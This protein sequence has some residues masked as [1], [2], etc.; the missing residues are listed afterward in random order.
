MTMPKK[1]P[2]LIAEFF[3]WLG[4]AVLSLGLAV[5]LVVY[6]HRIDVD[7]VVTAFITPPMNSGNMVPGNGSNYLPPANASSPSGA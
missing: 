4:L 1:S 2:S 3:T 5:P 6:E 7:N